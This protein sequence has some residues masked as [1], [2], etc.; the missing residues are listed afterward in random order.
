LGSV[1]AGSGSAELYIGGSETDELNISAV[2]FFMLGS[3]SSYLGVNDVTV[4]DLTL[5]VDCSNNGAG[6]AHVKIAGDNSV[7]LWTGESDGSTIA[8]YVSE[9]GAVGIGADPGN[10]GVERGSLIVGDL[11]SGMA[12]A[13]LNICDITSVGNVSTFRRDSNT[14]KINEYTATTVTEWYDG[15]FPSTSLI[16]RLDGSGHHH[17]VDGTTNLPAYSFINNVTAGMYY[18]DTDTRLEWSISTNLLMYLNYND[19]LRVTLGNGTVNFLI[20]GNQ[21]FDCSLTEVVVNNGGLDSVDLRV[22]SDNYNNMLRV[23]AEYDLVAI[24]KDGGWTTGGPADAAL[25]ICDHTML[26]GD[27]IYDVDFTDATYSTI[28]RVRALSIKMIPT[29][30]NAGEDALTNYTFG[31]GT[32]LTDCGPTGTWTYSSGWVIPGQTGRDIGCA[33]IFPLIRTGNWEFKVT[34]STVAHTASDE[35]HISLGVISVG[36]FTPFH[37]VAVC[38]SA[39]IAAPQFC[40]SNGNGGFNM[41]QS[42]GS[43]GSLPGT[44]SLGIRYENGC[45]FQWNNTTGSW[46]TT[47]WSG[48]FGTSGGWSQFGI[49]HLYF[50]AS[51]EDVLQSSKDVT[52]TN[53]YFEYLN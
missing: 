14:L 22:E 28:S 7:S 4:S 35:T 53:V 31:N 42:A 11:T 48:V 49:D 13:A 3:N 20:S 2:T 6:D 9:V 5:T 46:H 45:F 38:T 44:F 47:A 8:L 10:Y 43:A 1:N 40:T 23:N 29:G 24:S 25:N 39:G 12:G 21:I 27:V 18:N 52:V 32:W 50:L 51:S 15:D 33:L 34:F 26:L 16:Y 30:L 19:G 36:N 37:T 41:Q 17:A